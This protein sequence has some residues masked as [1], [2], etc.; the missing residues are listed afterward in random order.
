M[1]DNLLKAILSMD[2][3]N[4]G[5]LPGIK[6]LGTALGE[7]TLTADSSNLGFVDGTETRKDQAIGFYAQV[8][9]D[10]NGQKI[11]SFRGTDNIVQDA[12]TGWGLGAL[13]NED[14][15]Q[16][17]MALDFYQVVAGSGN[18]LG[19]NIALTGHSLGGGLAGYIG[20]IYDQDAI[21]FDS[22]A[23]KSG[24]DDSWERASQITVTWKYTHLSTEY[25]EVV[26][27]AAYRD[28]ENDPDKEIIED[29]YT[30]AAFRL[31]I[32]GT[33][34][35]LNQDL[36]AIDV[37]GITGFYV[38]GEAL[39][40]LQ[41][42]RVSPDTG[43]ELGDDVNLYPDT[44]DPI[45]EAIARHDMA[46][47]VIRLFA[48]KGGAEGTALATEWEAIAP[49]LWPALYDDEMAKKA[50]VGSVEG[51]LS[52]DAANGKTDKYS[53]IAR[54]IIAYSAIDEGTR[55]FGDTAI[56]VL[57]KN[58]NQFGDLAEDLDSDHA[59]I[60]YAADI[61][62]VFTQFSIHLALQSVMHSSSTGTSAMGTDNNDGEDSL[63]VVTGGLQLDFSDDLWKVGAGTV[64]NIY[65]REALVTSIMD[66]TGFKDKMLENM[67]RIWGS[68]TPI[69]LIEKIL[70]LTASGDMSVSID[71]P[72]SGKVKFYYGGDDVDTV[73]GSSGRDMV[74]SG[75]G[76]DIINLGGDDDLAYGD[77]GEDTLNGGAGN[78]ALYGGDNDDVINGEDGNDILYGGT[79]EDLL[80]AGEGNDTLYGGTSAIFDVLEGDL[81]NGG[82]G[83][84]TVDYSMS[85]KGLLFDISNSGTGF[86]KQWNSFDNSTSGLEDQLVSIENIV[87][88]QYNDKFIDNQNAANIYDGGAGIETFDYSSYT[89]AVTVNVNGKIENG[90]DT[91]IN[92]ENITGSNYNDTFNFVGDLSGRTIH[93]DGN[94]QQASGRDIADFSTQQDGVTIDKNG[95]VGGSSITLSNFEIF[96]GGSGKDIVTATGKLD[97]PGGAYGGFIIVETGGGN[98]EVTAA[99]RGIIVDL[100]DGADTLKNA[101]YGVVVYTGAGDGDKDTIEAGKYLFIAD[102][103]SED[104]ITFGG[105]NLTGGSKWHYS[106]NPY[107]YADGV[108]YGISSGD[109][110]LV[111]YTPIKD[112]EGN[113]WTTFV[114]NYT[115]T[116]HG[117]A[118]NTAGILLFET[119]KEV[120][121]IGE[122]TSRPKNYQLLDTK[123]L[124]AVLEGGLGDN[125]TPIY[126]DPIVFDLDGDG[127]E[128][129]PETILSPHFDMDGDGF[130]ERA[131]WIKGDDAF[132]V[133]DLNANGK[134]DDITEMFGT[135]TMSGYAH[136]ATLDLNTD[137]KI[138]SAD[139]VW[140]DLKLWRDA[141]GDGI[142]DS[143][144]LLTLASQNIASIDVV[145]DN[146]VPQ[147]G[148]N[149]A[150]TATGV[151]TRDDNS[152]GTT[153]NIIYRNN[154]HDT[155]WLTEVTVS[156]AAEELP[157]IMG[158]GTLPDLRKAMTVSAALL[159][160]VENTL[161][162]MNTPN[163]MALQAAVL[164]ILNAWRA[165]ATVPV[166]APGTEARDDIYILTRT[167]VKDGTEVLDYAVRKTDSLGTY[168][169]LASNENVNAPGGAVI[170][171]PTLE[172]VLADNGN[173][174]GSWTVMKGESVQ[175]I[176]RWLGVSLPLGAEGTPT[177][178]AAQEA[179][180]SL[181]DTMYAELNKI[182]IRLVAQSDSALGNFFDGIEY[183]VDSEVF[184]PT[185][186]YQLSPMLETLFE[187]APADAVGAYDYML[188]W[189][190]L[191]SVLMNNFDRGG[192]LLPTYGFLFQNVVTA[193]ENVGFAGGLIKAASVLG[194]PED[195]IY[196]GSENLEGSGNADI[197]YL[198]AG[199]QI[200]RGNGGYDNFIVGRNFGQDK[201]I[202]VDSAA[203]SD[204]DDT[205]RFAHA[206][207][208]DV[209]A[210]RIGNDLILT[211][212]GTTDTL[213]IVDQFKAR[214]PGLFG[215]YTDYARG[216]TE[217]I[218]ANGEVWDRIDMAYAV[219]HPL[220]S[221]DTLTGT[222]RVD[223]MDGGAG[224]DTLKGGGDG[225]IYIYNVGYGNDLIDDVMGDVLINNPDYVAFGNNIAVEDV[226]FSR[227]GGSNDLIITIM[228]TGETLTVNNQ[229]NASYTGILGK[230]WFQRIELFAFSDGTTVE[231]DDLIKDMPASLKTT[232][233]DTI[234]GFSWEDTLD[235]GA[236][237]DYLSGGN[238]NDTYIFGLGYGH[239]TIRDKQSDVVSTNSIDTV[240]FL[241][242]INPDEVTVTRIGDSSNL[243]LTFIDGSTLTIERQFHVDFAG[244]GGVQKFDQIEYFKF[245]DAEQTV[246][247]AE[248][249]INRAIND[250]ITSGNDYTYGFLREDSFAASAGDDHIYGDEEG[251]DYHFGRGS[252]HDVIYD[253]AGAI[254]FGDNIDRIVMAS[255][256][257]PSDI[258]LL[259]GPDSNDLV[260][261]IKDTGDTI[262]ILNQNKKYVIGQLIHSIEQIVFAD[263]TTWSAQDLRDMY[264]ANAATS[265]N[266]T[267]YG[268]WYADTIDG[269]A[270]DDYMAGGGAGDTYLWGPGAGNDIIH[271]YIQYY[272]WNQADTIQFDLS[273]DST[274]AIFTKIGDDLKI[275]LVGYTD[276]LIVDKFFNGTG[277]F[278]IEHFEFS[279]TTLSK[280]DVYTLT[281][282]S[283]H[284]V[285][286][287]AANTLSGTSGNDILEGMAGNDTLNG[288]A[289]EDT[290][291]GGDGNDSLNGSSEN[292]T[293]VASFGVDVIDEGGG[294][295]EILFGPGITLEDLNI[296]RY[297]GSYPYQHLAVEWGD[298]NKI[299]VEGNYYGGSPVEQIRF[300]DGSTY[301]LVTNP[302]K[303]VGS[304]GNSDLSGFSVGNSSGISPDDIMYG[305]GGNDDISGYS[306]NDTI[307]GGTGNDIMRGGVDDDTYVASAGLDYIDEDGGVDEIL[308]SEGIALEDLIF[309][310]VDDY[311][312]SHLDISWGEGNRIRIG[313][314]YSPNISSNARQVEFLRFADGTVF[315]L[316]SSIITQRGTESADVMIG[317]GTNTHNI[318]MDDSLY[319]NGGDDN[320]DSRSG[321]D[322]VYG[323][324][325]A[326]YITGGS[327]DDSIDGNEDSD[328]VYGEDG[329]DTIYGGEGNDARLDGGNG[330][331]TIYGGIG[332]DLI[333]GGTSSSASGNDLLYGE[334]GDDTIYGGVGNDYLD[335]AEGNDILNGEGGNDRLI[336]AAGNDTLHGGSG[337]DYIVAGIG[338][339]TITGGDG[340]DTIDA[341]DGND[342]IDAGAYN[343]IVYGGDGDD[344]INPGTGND[345]IYGGSGND[346]ITALTSSNSGDDLKYIHGE[347][348]D[349]TITMADAS[350]HVYGGGGAD[351]INAGSGNDYIEGG[352]GDDLINAGNHTD[353]VYGG[354]GNDTIDPGTGND[355]VYGGAGDDII[356]ATVASG[357]SD[358]A[359]YI[360]GDS[361]NDTI[362]MAD[363]AD[364]I[365]GG[366]GNDII[367]G[368]SG[369]DHIFGGDGNDLIT[370]GN[371]NDVMDGG[372]GDDTY[373]YTYG[374][375][376]DFITDAGGNDTIQYLATTSPESLDFYTENHDGGAVADDVKIDYHGTTTQEIVV[377]NQISTTWTGNK[378]ETLAFT[379]LFSLNFARYGTAQWIQMG[380]ST[381]TQDSSAAGEGRTI[382]GGTNANT[383]TG[384]VHADEIHADTGNDVIHGGSGNDL[385]HGGTGSDTVNGGDGDDRIWGGAGT[386]ALSGGAGDDIYYYGSG[387][388]L[389]LIEESGG[390]DD[391][392]V[393]QHK[394]QSEVTLTQVGND[395]VIDTDA[396]GSNKI[397][398]D[399]FYVY[400]NGKAVETIE[401]SN[402]VTFDLTTLISQPP[403]IVSSGGNAT[404]FV[405]ALENDA[406][407]TTVVATDH[408]PG[409]ALAYSIIGGADAD[410]FS[411]NATTG[412]LSFVSAQNYESPADT[413]ANNVYDV[414]VQVSDGTLTDTQ[415]IAVTVT[416]VNEVPVITSNG[417]NATA[418]TSVSEN[419]TVVT[420]VSASDVD[421]S[422]TLTYAIVGGSDSEKF[423]INSLTGALTF[424]SVQNFEFPTDTGADNVYDVQ[425]QVSDGALTD[426]QDIAVTVTDTNEAPAIVSDSG[427]SAASVNAAENDTT[428]T[429]VMASDVDESTTLSYSITGGADSDKFSINATTG[430][431]SFVSAPNF[432]FPAD[433]G[434]NNVYDVQVQVSDGTL[435]D[436]Q[437]IAVTVTNVNEV[438]VIT[439]NGGNATAAID[440]LEEATVVTTVTATDVDLATTY[441]YAITGGADSD[442]F[443]INADTGALSFVSTPDYQNPTD[444][445]ADN[446]YE[447]QVQVSDGSL[448][449]VQDIAVTV[450]NANQAPIAKDDDLTTAYGTSLSGNVIVD[451]G[452][453]ADF[454][455]DMDTVNAVAVSV[456]SVQGVTVNIAANGDFIYTPKIGY[457][458]NDTFIY[459]VSD[460][461]GGIDTATVTVSI[462]VP[463][464]AIIGTSAA[465]TITGT[466]NADYIF[467]LAGNDT[468]NGSGGNDILHGDDG[469]DV[470]NGGDGND[471][472]VGGAGG[473]TLNGGAGTD[474]A[475][476]NADSTGFVIY[477]PSTSYIRVVDTNSGSIATYVHDT[478]YNDVEYIVFNDI[479]ID[480]TT[481]TFVN[482]GAGWGT[483]LPIYGTSSGEGINAFAGNDLIYAGDGNDTVNA[484]HG[485]NT[486]YGEG[487]ADIITGGLGVDTFYGG[488]AGDTLNGME[489]NDVLDGGIGNDVLNG[490]DG[491]DTLVGGA[492]GDTLNG[493]GGNDTLDGG[494]GNDIYTGGA[495]TDTVYLNVDS[496]G[497]VVYRDHPGYLKVRDTHDQT[498]ATYEMVYNDIENLVFNDVTLNL[499][500]MTFMTLGAGWGTAM[501][502]YGTSSGE[503]ITGTAVADEIY[504]GD[505]TDTV[506]SGYGN[507]TV[508]GEGGND[509][510]NG[511]YGTDTLYGGAGVDTL[512]GNDDND[513]LY[514]NDGNDLLYGEGGNDILYGHDGNDALDGGGG[515]DTLYGG[516]GND[517]YTGSTGVDTVYLNVDSAGFVVYR[518]HPNYLKVRDT[519]DQTGATYEMVYNDIENLVFNDVTLNLTTM[520]FMTL[521]AGWG[522]AMPYYGTSSGETIAGTAVDDEIYAGSGNDTINAGHGNDVVYG[523]AGTDSLNGEFGN[524]TLYGG[525]ANDTLNGNEGNDVLYGGAG[526]DSMTGSTGADT[527]VFESASAFSNIDTI[528]DF[529][530]SQGDAID[531]TDLL[532]QYDPLNDAITDFVEMTASGSHTLL[533][534]D[535]DGT[536]ST[537]GWTQIATL[538][539]VTGLT[540]EAALV[541]NGNLIV[542]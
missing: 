54:Q 506:T 348:G 148:P 438:P 483:A 323:G 96:K 258:E 20:S 214:P 71:A 371:S 267:I 490:G 1:D 49:Y 322:S 163:L 505:G 263:S 64:P 8:Y 511:G 510:I 315:D 352:L 423:S 308:F 86:A 311:P 268:Y 307:D 176:E 431:L 357:S 42:W 189:K 303:T 47:L 207:S 66:D 523:E 215:G 284:R 91:L 335:G 209:I 316:L 488:D 178:N 161:P 330:D 436:T 85:G 455:P 392:I 454:D 191:L 406:S 519:H 301:S 90:A 529:N 13:D 343:D 466:A 22:M 32:Y 337:D 206:L 242:G 259:S 452:N 58:A 266:D 56:R 80:S 39:D 19:A 465:E 121:R 369:G 126:A 225:D 12:L 31:G 351:I 449:D 514:G 537:Y 252:G 155:R 125:Y 157:D 299:V 487:G 462:T 277:F 70:F 444:V 345:V 28:I 223:V 100:G 187:A 509:T 396:T 464:G 290:L 306:G 88:T 275:E 367:N 137:G 231:W 69:D 353:T 418:S 9:T 427:G 237:N 321:N 174:G 14:V 526:V 145:P 325:G 326:D 428:V 440:V 447:V 492:G 74:F 76:D 202:E 279:D 415:D 205:V 196:A 23:F 342:T 486:V 99:G 405:N 489:G 89:A 347:D 397:T 530:A 211:I 132:L 208:T 296:Y 312:Y 136:M 356:Q 420:T 254:P 291:D 365:F 475:I 516:A 433:T 393:I 92:I 240:Q 160:V 108:K 238:E 497:F 536:D 134:I 168:W 98:D 103:G 504:A 437:D 460:G 282:G 272:T 414:Q 389:D 204:A 152:T 507:D 232:G 532:S 503:T 162:L 51:Q 281:V 55:P 407:V 522:T 60:K 41:P 525:D 445:G 380:N 408:N 83:N 35:S 44:I 346:Q 327:G 131:G 310:R 2:S 101:G 48:D 484:S 360:Y 422:T 320:I 4:R 441:I 344:I 84:D 249:L 140:A 419:S 248:Y 120:F 102:A 382:L 295:D 26:N 78:D 339:D 448:T 478:I 61:S 111:I 287:D 313:D 33:S 153:G 156:A 319:G 75:D 390:A 250:T 130:A 403:I 97:A 260:L 359:K 193:Y 324:A 458:G 172:D 197:F 494:A 521:G 424:V 226:A 274:D 524:D 469:N 210:T 128:I 298:G 222:G 388:G 314:F 385:L 404:A 59:V 6:L 166:G 216:I 236:G 105:Q 167:T 16:A 264:I 261:K 29:Y 384:S 181:L 329:L 251:D 170:A 430:V 143:G 429:M 213:T 5:Y 432:E 81:L 119:D 426:V 45:G 243:V 482:G 43:L 147:A 95:A 177:G 194:V 378:I 50:G 376:E 498:G 512:S 338:N 292:D 175:F 244:I 362:S 233:N 183:D 245:S 77:G 294:F 508:Y 527:F 289:G 199:N 139:A 173:D 184:R 358:D 94:T 253:L 340:N 302:V 442:K 239:D 480:L 474:S 122:I 182:V 513:S 377:Y 541:T 255:D 200:V 355:T 127:L 309:K 501:P 333:Y 399:D 400:G 517:T 499:T 185:T 221:S 37:N 79:G 158:R 228:S 10:G 409:T 82:A 410:K 386:D 500:T 124:D 528:A 110:S 141:D 116:L 112:A 318:N 383:I 53:Q 107:T 531:I 195:A 520:T 180:L 190:P 230:Q 476:W 3:Y 276:S 21:I 372:L 104:R 135:T 539:N 150:V 270:G 229:F 477:R 481:T 450:N 192:D 496:A 106:E 247:T 115:T 412:V 368:N 283:V 479:T 118:G 265:G 17:G 331:D 518:D 470:L 288:G 485:N 15:L 425:V 218:F 52:E 435:T 534:V 256:V 212:E 246:W 219:S 502:Y 439:S 453:G 375:D 402:G 273:I 65:A 443:S 461:N 459:T 114:A 165:V 198:D 235:G 57:F 332:N 354:D 262:T 387:G 457:L 364:H 304:D 169:K 30:D 451:N 46:L 349:D 113:Y 285:G 257:L 164:P 468:L 179:G 40:G 391:R 36:P 411:I 38:E 269:G 515:D 171:R 34:Y 72:S 328:T 446:V 381:A 217:I 68:S 133:R 538:S 109:G 24:A 467:G 434:A 373:F 186:D 398:I 286:T 67:Q 363:A 361:G 493:E 472:L 280:G 278:A 297:Y 144:E 7:L 224:N 374:E 138:D 317:A 25:T 395:L 271:D 336:G 305:M 151:Y 417:G 117:S 129:R 341:G 159:D 220:S 18:W 201:I 533:K 370:G 540:D 142:T 334:D 416:N 293:Y 491:N 495:G 87:G 350:D 542:S 63:K 535:Q 379:D 241:E 234:Y 27:A 300:D 456:L 401:Y 463:S 146:T 93:A 188:G 366:D 473:D 471:T 203:G 11:I 123:L 227:T 154:A 394:L 73:T 421:E 413:G 62:K 149:Y